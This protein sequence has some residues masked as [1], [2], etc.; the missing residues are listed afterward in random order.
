MYRK[1]ELTDHQ[2]HGNLLL[3][4]LGSHRCNRQRLI[5]LGAASPSKALSVRSTLRRQD[6]AVHVD[7][8]EDEVLCCKS[9]LQLSVFAYQPLPDWRR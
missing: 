9:D 1:S 8:D 5:L 4:P 6:R 3:R 2:V 7:K